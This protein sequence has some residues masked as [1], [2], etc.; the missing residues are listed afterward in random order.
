[1]PIIQQKNAIDPWLGRCKTRK[2]L[3]VRTETIFHST[4]SGKVGL[5]SPDLYMP[6]TLCG[7]REEPHV[8]Q[9]RISS[10][11]YLIWVAGHVK[12]P[13]VTAVMANGLLP[14]LPPLSPGENRNEI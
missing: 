11:T 8:F 7:K 6:T 10:D 5:E 2:G 9:Q 14:S 13:L 3:C 12:D 1:M 4:V